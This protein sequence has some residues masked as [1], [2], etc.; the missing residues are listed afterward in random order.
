MLHFSLKAGSHE[1]SNS[2]SRRK[3]SLKVRNKLKTR[4]I[5]SRLLCNPAIQQG[6]KVPKV[7]MIETRRAGRGAHTHTPMDASCHLKFASM[8]I[9]GLDHESFW[10]VQELLRHRE[11][12][13]IITCIS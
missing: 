6:K 2:K 12:D 5:V 3:T 7:K 11:F 9:N 4:A 13:V 8:N 1:M 10:A